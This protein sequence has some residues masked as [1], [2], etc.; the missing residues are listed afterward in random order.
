M[1]KKIYLQKIGELEWSILIKLKKDLEWS[2][3]QFSLSVKIC[4]D[5]IPLTDLE[6]N[7][8]R[9]QHDASIV[10]DRLI[11]HV[12]N[13]QYFRTLGVMDKDIFSRFLNFVF[14]IAINPQKRFLKFSGAALI[15]ITRLKE[16]FYG[17]KED[18]ALLELRVLKEALHELGHTFGLGHCENLCIMQ[19]SNSLVNTD[20]KPPKFCYTC[21]RELNDFFIHKNNI[22]RS[23]P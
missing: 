20:E 22:F 17:R 18:I 14:G 9:R 23:V 5:E 1:K 21:L 8:L 3:K 2:L 15:S 19:F 11:N 13:K 12:K 16:T 7:P 6:F 4:P 10:M